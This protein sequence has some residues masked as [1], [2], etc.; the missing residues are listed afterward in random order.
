LIAIA[1]GRPQ[2]NGCADIP[3][4]R[5]NPPA[6]DQSCP[7]P[8]CLSEFAAWL[9]WPNADDEATFYK[10]HSR[11]VWAP[12]KM[13]C[14]C[15]TLFDYNV[16]RCVHPHEWN[17]QCT[18]HPATPRPKDCPVCPGCGEGNPPTQNPT[19]PTNPTT[20]PTV[21]TNPTPWPT[22]PTNPTPWPTNPTNPGQCPCICAPCVIWPCS[23]CPRNCPC[24]QN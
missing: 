10:C 24:M 17:R 13:D 21:P 9:L 14:A 20:W 5:P 22:V 1:S 7:V 6:L 2:N 3:C 4:P 18:R 11:G 8:N 23:P 19:W 15:A 16:Q 12:V